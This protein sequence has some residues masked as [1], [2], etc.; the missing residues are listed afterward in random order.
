[1]LETGTHIVLKEYE[2]LFFDLARVEPDISCFQFCLTEIDGTDNE[3]SC[4]EHRRDDINCPRNWQTDLAMAE[5]LNVSIDTTKHLSNSVIDFPTRPS[6]LSLL[7]SF[8][9]T[10]DVVDFFRPIFLKRVTLRPKCRVLIPPG[11]LAKHGSWVIASVDHGSSYE[12]PRLE[13]W[14]GS[15]ALSH[16]MEGDIRSFCSPLQDEI[17]VSV[18]ALYPNRNFGS[19]IPPYGFSLVGKLGGESEDSVMKIRAPPG[20]ERLQTT[21]L[22][23]RNQA[24]VLD[25]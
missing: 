22:F 21:W 4:G 17:D 1:M 6:C 12:A 14:I 20:L 13:R 24:A 3:S 10:R 2:G 25:A 18:F 8:D 9:F 15:L 16:H 11:Y 23:A 7:S 19:F 5:K